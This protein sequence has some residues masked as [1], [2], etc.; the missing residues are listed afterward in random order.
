[1]AGHVP[2]GVAAFDPAVAGVGRLHGGVR[3]QDPELGRL[4]VRQPDLDVLHVV[5]KTVE[6]H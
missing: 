3:A 4:V 5:A 1:M 6:A 2:V